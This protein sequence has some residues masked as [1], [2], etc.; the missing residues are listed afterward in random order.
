ML[1]TE[2]EERFGMKV[3]PEE[4]IV[5][6]KMYNNCNLDKDAFVREYK[7]VGASEL[8]RQLA[9]ACDAMVLVNR[10]LQNQQEETALFIV[11]RV[12][13][14]GKVEPSSIQADL[15]TKAK[16]MLGL[17]KYLTYKLERGYELSNEERKAIVNLISK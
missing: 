2:F 6:E 16:L 7:K 8:V 9:T 12:N 13:E 4:Y 17:K 10:K 5:I 14:I 15:L 11:D 3:S 1:Q